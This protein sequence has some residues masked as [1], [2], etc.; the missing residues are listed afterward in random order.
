VLLLLALFAAIFPMRKQSGMISASI[1]QP[2]GCGKFVGQW[3]EGF[4]L[5]RFISN[6]EPPSRISALYFGG[7]HCKNI[8]Q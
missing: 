7:S 5:H 3:G 2:L 1:A 6:P 4:F 8:K